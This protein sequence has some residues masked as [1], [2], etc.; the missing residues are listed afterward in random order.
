MNNNQNNPIPQ[1]LIDRMVKDR[2]V[3]TAITRD[4]HWYFFHFYFAHYIT[5]PTAGFQR[6]II[7]LTEDDSVKNIFITAFRGSGKSTIITTS[8]PLWAILGKQQKKFV[9][10]LGHTQ[11][12]AKQHMMNIRRELETNELL[13]NDLGPFREESDEWGST[14]L[15]FTNHNARITAASTDQAI[16]G[17]R[18]NQ[19]R[20]DLIIGD[21]VEDINSTKTREGR[22][23]TYN[24]FTGEVVPAG[25]RNTRIVVVGNLLHEDSL[26]MRIRERIDEGK[27]EGEFRYI[28]L[29]DDKE[30]VLWPGKYPTKKDL[31]D[32]YRKVGNEIAWRREYLLEI[33]SDEEQV[34][35]PEWIKYYPE[36]PDPKEMSEVR[37]A[38][39]PA[40]STKS[41][42]DYTAILPGVVTKYSS[43]SVL[44][45]LPG[46]VNARLTFPQ[47]VE[48]CVQLNKDL[49]AMYP[50]VYPHFYVEDVG[51]QKAL[52]QVLRDEGLLVDAVPSTSDK[53]S[54]L[55]LTG[56]AVQKGKVLFPEKGCERV[57]EQIVHF[58]VEKYDDLADAFSTI[59]LS[60]IQSPIPF[61]GFA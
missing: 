32:E 39:D 37:V 42:A 16:R 27:M 34:I 25:D 30:Q 23:K 47:T 2:S 14:S 56:S 9:L 7:R 35:F 11:S 20:P 4:S 48:K 40:V 55:A 1:N 43:D 26:L 28:P 8:Y 45:L 13:K 24:W 18:H 31:D 29:L 6:D 60:V 15:V 61:I 58:G 22:N 10:L 3:R 44:Y 33:V 19:Y 57:I 53:R 50:R 51:Y 5:F 52:V 12:Q 21:D 38:I 54:R 36:L 41:S 46:A 59:V 17:L 49:M